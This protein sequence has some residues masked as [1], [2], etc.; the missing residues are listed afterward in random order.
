MQLP[1]ISHA[2]RRY[3]CLA[4]RGAR[5]S[6]GEGA[7]IVVRPGLGNRRISQ[8]PPWMAEALAAGLRGCA[9]VVKLPGV[10]QNDLFSEPTVW[11]RVHSFLDSLKEHE[12]DSAGVS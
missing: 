11:R 5:T 7:A 4:F 12:D 10:G 8:T 2:Q 3:A 9:E 1:V 6:H